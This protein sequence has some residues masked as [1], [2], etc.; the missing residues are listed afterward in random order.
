MGVLGGSRAHVS[1]LRIKYGGYNGVHCL[2][3]PRS[4]VD[5]NG[6]VQVPRRLP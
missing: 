2:L 5:D 3:V 6:R 4:C 1:S